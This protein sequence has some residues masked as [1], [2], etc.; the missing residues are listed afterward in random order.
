[1]YLALLG[2]RTEECHWH[3]VRP[4]PSNDYNDINCPGMRSCFL[5]SASLGNPVRNNNLDDSVLKML[6]Y[7]PVDLGSIRIGSQL[8]YVKKRNILFND[9]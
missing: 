3:A 5:P 2:R 7:C 8:N 6:V 4:L 9:M 1:M